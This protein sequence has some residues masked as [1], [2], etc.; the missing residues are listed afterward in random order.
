MFRSSVRFMKRMVMMDLPRQTPL[1]RWGKVNEKQTVR[2]IELANED[3]CS[4]DDLM[5]ILRSQ[6]VSKT[7]KHSADG[8]RNLG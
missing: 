2:R 5:S 4:C 7:S 1:G 3:H 6:P 8:P